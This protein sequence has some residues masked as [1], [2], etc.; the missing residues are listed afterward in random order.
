VD[1]RHVGAKMNAEIAPETASTPR[2][3][4]RSDLP[5]ELPRSVRWDRSTTMSTAIRSRE[6]AC[7]ESWWW[8]GAGQS[9]YRARTLKW[10]DDLAPTRER[11]Y[12]W[13]SSRGHL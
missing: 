1:D 12:K 6:D 8:S 11:T 9:P 3:R 5:S 10:P 7:S 13:P 4:A 2:G